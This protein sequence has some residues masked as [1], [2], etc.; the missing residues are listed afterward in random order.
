MHWR[1]QLPLCHCWR[2]GPFPRNGRPC[3]ETT[4]QWAEAVKRWPCR[5]IT[6]Q[7]CNS[8]SSLF[9]DL[10][11]SL[12]SPRECFGGKR[13]GAD[14]ILRCYCSQSN[15]ATYIQYGPMQTS[16]LVYTATPLVLHTVVHVIAERRASRHR[17]GGAAAA[18]EFKVAP[19]RTSS[20]AVGNA[21][22]FSRKC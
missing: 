17:G 16:E 1:P 19:A 7:I 4:V 21:S 14:K 12:P 8:L 9:F 10:G 18:A 22:P 11:L 20:A 3:L 6:R 2:R 5:A 15:T 13:S